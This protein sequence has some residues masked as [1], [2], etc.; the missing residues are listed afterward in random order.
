L[1]IHFTINLKGSKP[2]PAM[3]EISELY[4]AR[5]ATQYIPPPILTPAEA[6][7][8]NYRPTS[9]AVSPITKLKEDK[10]L[11]GLPLLI[12]RHKQF[13]KENL[14]WNPEEKRL[15]WNIA[16]YTKYIANNQVELRQ[17][18][19]FPM[20]SDSE[21]KPL[22]AVSRGIE[23]LQSDDGSAKLRKDKTSCHTYHHHFRIPMKSSSKRRF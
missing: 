5:G 20:L 9:F 21:F 3:D 17:H 7:P 15:L 2:P 1:K 22:L 4:S 16:A 10:T 12:A 11:N 14:K 6:A 23:F 8:T 19:C 18:P 13:L